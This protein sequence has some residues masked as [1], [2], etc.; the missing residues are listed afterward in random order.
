MRRKEKRE[1]RR[2]TDWEWV[3]AWRGL[4]NR[5]EFDECIQKDTDPPLEISFPA[6]QTFKPPALF[7]RR[8]PENHDSPQTPFIQEKSGYIPPQN[9]NLSKARKDFPSTL[10][11]FSEKSSSMPERTVREDIGTATASRETQ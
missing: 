7:F 6:G 3:W 8:F 5:A 2:G 9:T 11:Y 1:K 4:E 10:R